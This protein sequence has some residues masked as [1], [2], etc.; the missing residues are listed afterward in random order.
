[1]TMND[2][3]KWLLKLG[4]AAVSLWSLIQDGRERG[5]V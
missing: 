1:M 2:Q 4:I 5:W 3:I